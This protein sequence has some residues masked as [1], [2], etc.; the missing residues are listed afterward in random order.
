MTDETNAPGEL[1]AQGCERVD[2]AVYVH[3]ILAVLRSLDP[4]QCD[5]VLH[6]ALELNRAFRIRRSPAAPE[7][8][9]L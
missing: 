9:S 4:T 8:E 2:L 1:V 6:A 3:R 7:D 5:V